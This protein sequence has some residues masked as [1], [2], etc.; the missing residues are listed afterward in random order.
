[1]CGC[2]GREK[3]KDNSFKPTVN[4]KVRVGTGTAKAFPHEAGA[5]MRDLA[6]SKGQEGKVPVRSTEFSNS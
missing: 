1:M 3:V 5:V 4:P 6:N 2:L